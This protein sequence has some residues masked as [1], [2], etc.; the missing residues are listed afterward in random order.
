MRRVPEAS[1]A[2]VSGVGQPGTDELL[3]STGALLR[4]GDVAAAMARLAEALRHTDHPELRL[5]YGQLAYFASD[6]GTA[7]EQLEAAV[8]AFLAAGSRRRAAVAAARPGTAATL[9]WWAFISAAC[10]SAWYE[11]RPATGTVRTARGSRAG[12]WQRPPR[13]G[14]RTGCGRTPPHPARAPGRRCPTSTPRR[15]AR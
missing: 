15:P 12:P 4:A 5:R 7:R 8:A 1:A 10:R 9:A 3:E 2:D 13:C 14:G 6:F 11:H